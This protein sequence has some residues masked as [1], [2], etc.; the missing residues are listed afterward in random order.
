LQSRL[1]EIRALDAE[2]LAVSVDSIE[3]NQRLAESAGI[4]FS[5]LSDREASALD[6]FGLRHVG[7]SI[8]GGD[9]AR[10]AIFIVGRDGKIRWRDLTDNWRVRVRPETII[11]QLKKLP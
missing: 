6:A 3:E 9:I 10:P 1:N 5:L 2:V 7:G 11:E 8:D 4:G